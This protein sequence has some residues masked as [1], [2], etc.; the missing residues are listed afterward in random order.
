MFLT[1]TSREHEPSFGARL[2]HMGVS[3]VGLQCDNTVT[4]HVI[5]AMVSASR[6]MMRELQLLKRELDRSNVHIDARWLPSVLKKYADA[7][8]RRFPRGDLRIR[9][10]LRR[11]VANGMRAP[12][13]EFPYRPLGENLIFLRRQSMAALQTP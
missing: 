11:S 13:T 5:N 4:V 2:R 12:A 3:T 6:P 7:L 8:S 9:R 1:N 10:S